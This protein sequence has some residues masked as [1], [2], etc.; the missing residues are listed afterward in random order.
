MRIGGNGALRWNDAY[1]EA[2]RLKTEGRIEQHCN[3]VAHC[4]VFWSR[5][6]KSIVLVAKRGGDFQFASRKFS[7]HR[8]RRKS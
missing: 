6:Q 3:S 1:L 8:V 7:V 5:D 4:K 2:Q